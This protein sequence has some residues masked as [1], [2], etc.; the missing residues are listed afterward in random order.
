VGVWLWRPVTDDLTAPVITP[1]GDFLDG[2]AQN[3]GL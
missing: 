1:G 3:D 2:A